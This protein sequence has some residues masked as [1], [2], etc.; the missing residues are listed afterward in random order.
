MGWEQKVG[1]VCPGQAYTAKK[2]KKK[3]KKSCDGWKGLSKAGCQKKCEQNAKAKHCPKKTCVAAAF[4][5]KSGWC[6]LYSACD[7]SKLQKRSTATLLIKPTDSEQQ[8]SD[9]VDL[10]EDDDCKKDWVAQT[11]KAM[12][13]LHTSSGA[14]LGAMKKAMASSKQTPPASRTS[15]ATPALAAW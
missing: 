14:H 12:K 2:K 9:V 15:G 6:H 1:K 5:P 7:A 11:G 3:K 13:H 10:D 4:Y 8:D